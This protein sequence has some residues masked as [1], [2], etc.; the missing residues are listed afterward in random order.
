[1]AGDLGFLPRRQ[2]CV[3]GA[4]LPVGDRRQPGDLVGDID[5]VGLRH[6][7]QLL[8]LDFE[9]GDGFFEIKEMTHGAGALAHFAAGGSG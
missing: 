7:P 4:Q 2:A 5:A 3:G 9:F 8:D 1:M 6:S